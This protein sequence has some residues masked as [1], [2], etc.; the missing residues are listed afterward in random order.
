MKCHVFTRSIHLFYRIVHWSKTLSFLST[1]SLRPHTLH[2]FMASSFG[3]M[4]KTIVPSGLKQLWPTGSVCADT[5][6]SRVSVGYECTVIELVSGEG[7]RIN[8]GDS[9]RS[10]VAVVGG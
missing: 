9:P 4:V 3:H 5:L 1:F 6:T 10:R 2:I 8:L 7:T